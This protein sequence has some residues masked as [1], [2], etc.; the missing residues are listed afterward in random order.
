MHVSALGGKVT[1]EAEVRAPETDGGQHLFPALERLAH[2]VGAESV[3]VGHLT[4]RKVLTVGDERVA[5]PV[6][7]GTI[8][9]G[10][11]VGPHIY[12]DASF[13]LGV[14]K[15]AESRHDP[16]RYIFF[17]LL[18]TVAHER[19]HQLTPAPDGTPE[20]LQM[21]ENVLSSANDWIAENV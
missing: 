21:V 1:S 9:L 8:L 11:N 6:R 12:V 13:A 19:A 2:A 17:R 18:S 3:S 20:H 14:A 10:M 7:E 4:H 16:A 5:L 15:E